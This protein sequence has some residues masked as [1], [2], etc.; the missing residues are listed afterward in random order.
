LAVTV[1]INP[2]AGGAR[3]E[4][5]RQRAE[6]AHAAVS[7][8]GDVPEVFVTERAGHARE[9]AEAAVAR[10]VRLVLAWGGDG[11]IN[12]IARV[13]AFKEVPLGIVPSGSGN[14]LAR[15]LGIDR[16]PDRA[17]A[18]ALRAEPRPMDAGEMGG[19]LFFN[20]AGIGFDA[21]VA[22]LFD[23]PSNQT[24]GLRKYVGISA[25]ALWS[26]EPGVYVI[27]T[28]AGRRET[29]AVLVTVANSAQF[30]NNARIAPGAEVDDGMLDLVVLAETARWRTVLQ[31]PRL[32]TGTVA[33]IPGCTMERVDRATIASARP[34]TFH[35]DGEPVRGGTELS[36]RVHPGALL[37]AVGQ[38]AT[39]AA[40]PTPS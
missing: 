3:P 32:F 26:Y 19:R 12:E 35:V 28:P 38:K 4:T 20:I 2:I 33:R 11:T 29:R 34:M 7:A 39:R 30:G 17:I 23:D 8:H 22:A 18:A 36:V 37:I 24:R 10:D 14:G 15:E 40:R 21:H 27:T 16:R 13:L 25:R 6:L 31:A 9:L 1:I 5:A